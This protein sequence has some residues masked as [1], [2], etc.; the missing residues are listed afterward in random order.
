MLENVKSSDRM[1]VHDVELVDEW[2]LRLLPSL[3]LASSVFIQ[4]LLV[5]HF[6][7]DLLQVGEGGKGVIQ[8]FFLDEVADLFGVDELTS[9]AIGALSI[10]M[11]LAAKLSLA[12]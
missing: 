6:I 9:I 4:N 7:L 3:Q 12:S 11:K 1:L 2:V 10:L 5:G 8:Q